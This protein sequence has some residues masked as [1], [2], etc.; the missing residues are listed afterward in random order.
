MSLCPKRFVTR[1]IWKAD[2][3]ADREYKKYLYGAELYVRESI[4]KGEQ[5]VCREKFDDP[6]VERKIKAMTASCQQF[7][8]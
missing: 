2:K 7:K 6:E 8:Q 4:V 3:T 1:P 5:I